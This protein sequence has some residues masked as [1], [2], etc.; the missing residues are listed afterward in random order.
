MKKLNITLIIAVLIG[1]T[2]QQKKVAPVVHI[3]Y[4]AIS[5]Y[6]FLID[7]LVTQYHDLYVINYDSLRISSKDI[8]DK[9]KASGI[10]QTLAYAKPNGYIYFNSNKIIQTQHELINILSHELFHTINREKDTILFEQPIKLHTNQNIYV[11]GYS[12]FILLG[13]INTLPRGVLTSLVDEGAA[14]SL[15]FAF[16][17]NKTISDKSYYHAGKIFN[18]YIKE[19]RISA[20][21]IMFHRKHGNIKTLFEEILNKN[22]SNKDIATLGH[23]FMKMRIQQIDD[24]V[25]YR[26][27]EKIK[28]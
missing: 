14:E 1:C 18:K 3:N 16:Y 25:A 10:S 17:K 11:D 15:A 7:S 26:Q 12:G 27:I 24:K 6:S 20:Q 23:I 19:N 4:K 9:R 21:K 2:R 13:K 8:P 22:L 28:H 5:K